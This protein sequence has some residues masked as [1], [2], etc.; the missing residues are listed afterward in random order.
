MDTLQHPSPLRAFQSA[1]G[2]HVRDP[3]RAPR[4]EGVPARR[5]AIYGEL[6]FGNLQGLLSPCFPVT[7]A[8]LGPRWPR[9]VRQFCREGRCE[10]PLFREVPGEFVQWL[11][12][13]PRTDIPAPPWLRELVHHEWSELAVETAPS[14]DGALRWVSGQDTSERWHEAPLRMNPASMNLHYRWPV[15]RIGPGYRPRKPRDTFMLVHRDRHE[16]VR[17][18]QLDAV[19]SRLLQLAATGELTAREACAAVAAELGSPGATALI[20]QGLALLRDWRRQ[21]VLLDTHEGNTP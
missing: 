6:V 21:D 12:T 19:S 8:V 5:A 7:R 2:R 17:F 20:D 1:L 11:L 14:E 15:H 16:A 18:T 10:T 13:T 9:L 4:P 3:R